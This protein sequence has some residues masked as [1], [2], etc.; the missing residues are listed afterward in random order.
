MVAVA[1]IAVAGMTAAGRCCLM[2]WGSSAAAGEGV[3][4]GDAVCSPAFAAG[5]TACGSGCAGD[6]AVLP[7]ATAF[8]RIAAAI[9]SASVGPGLGGELVLATVFAAGA[10]VA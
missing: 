1:C 5:S 10:A 7:W 6:C 2:F 4:A 9:M 8:A 3:L